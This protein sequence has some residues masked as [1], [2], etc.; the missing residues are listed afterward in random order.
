MREGLNELKWVGP[1][2]IHGEYFD[3]CRGK[4]TSPLLLGEPTSPRY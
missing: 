1:W 4:T 2:E 3:F